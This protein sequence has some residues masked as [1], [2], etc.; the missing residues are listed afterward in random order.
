MDVQM[1]KV[2]Q[3]FDKSYIEDVKSR[4]ESE[5]DRLKPGE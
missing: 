1:I 3:E 4:V 5:L 2:V